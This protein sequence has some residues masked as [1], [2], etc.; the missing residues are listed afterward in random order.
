MKPD[1]AEP[2]L[3]LADTSAWITYARFGDPKFDSLLRQHRVRGH[4]VVSGELSLGCGAT[5]KLLARAAAAI[6]Q[7]PDVG[8]DA[9]RSLVDSGDLACRGLS[10]PDATLIASA[11]ASRAAEGDACIYTHDVAL[12]ASAKRL[13]VGFE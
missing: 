10:W 8:H 9:V 12:A 7:A 1:F 6:P 3:V 4:A 13:G 2:R 11:L 5:A